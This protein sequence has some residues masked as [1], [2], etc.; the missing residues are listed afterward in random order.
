MARAVQPVVMLVCNFALQAAQRTNIEWR[1]MIS[2][3]GL[4]FPAE[5]DG[6]FFVDNF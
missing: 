3:L 2:K 6:P 5:F 1:V 4:I